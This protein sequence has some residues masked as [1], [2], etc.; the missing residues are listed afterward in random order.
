MTA[1]EKYFIYCDAKGNLSAR[2]VCSVSESQWYTQAI[3]LDTHSIRTFRRDR[4]IE[5]VKCKDQLPERLDY[6]QKQATKPD[7]SLAP[8]P[9]VIPNLKRK[10]S[11]S[12]DI[13]FTG[14]ARSEKE[15]LAG[16]AE[17][18][19]MIVRKSVTTN[20]NFLC[21]GSR[22]GPKKIETARNQAVVVLCEEQFKT[23]LRTGEI[24][25]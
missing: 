8:P 4:I 22:A 25:E 10:A 6:H 13:C 3:S 1:E 5:E 15:H 2:E 12:I 24:P 18:A 20:L 17:N 14:F 16:L 11:H 19:G 7:S 23:L 21:C 9:G